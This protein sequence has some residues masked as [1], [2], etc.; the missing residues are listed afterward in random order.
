MTCVE[1]GTVI[2]FVEQDIEALQEEVC[3][4][5]RFLPISHTLHIHG[6][7]ESCQDRARWH[8]VRGT[9]MAGRE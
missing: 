5:H 4:R 9:P 3:R 1:C 6:V 2:E 7:C 8:V